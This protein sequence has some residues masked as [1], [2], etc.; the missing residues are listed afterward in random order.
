MNDS[1]NITRVMSFRQRS[2]Q[3]FVDKLSLM[4]ALGWV[5]WGPMNDPLNEIT[6]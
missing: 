6:G 1:M 4:C 3:S 2:I 5:V